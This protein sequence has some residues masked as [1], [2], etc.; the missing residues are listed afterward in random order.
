[1]F[2]KRILFFLLVLPFISSCS[3]ISS[4]ASTSI[5]TKLDYALYYS[6]KTN[7]KGIEIYCWENEDYWYSGILPGTNRFKS[8]EEVEWL[9]ENLPCPLDE[10][11]KILATYSEEMLKYAPVRI[12]S[13]PPK[14]L[15]IT[16]NINEQNKIDKYKYVYG[17]L[18]LNM[19]ELIEK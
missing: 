9:Q 12:V 19:P 11:A 4:S 7:M 17:K 16:S 13:I 10:M 5:S 1:M 15:E 8:V 3:S 18:G 14:E 2:K 6:Y